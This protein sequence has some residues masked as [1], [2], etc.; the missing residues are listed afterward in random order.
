MVC[1]RVERGDEGREGGLDLCDLNVMGLEKEREGEI[2][3]GS[4][5]LSKN[6]QQNRQQ[7][8]NGYRHDEPTVIRKRTN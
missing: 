5:E 2:E 1:S 4:V 8:T 6:R 7:K 3:R